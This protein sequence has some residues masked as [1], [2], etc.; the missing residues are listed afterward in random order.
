M[1]TSYDVPF[2]LI[3]TGG[4][5]PVSQELLLQQMRTQSQLAM[6]EADVI[7]FLMDGRAGLT[8]ADREVAAMLRKIKKPVFYVVNK[9]DGDKVE[10]LAAEFYELGIDTFY[11]ISA[12]HNRGVG[13]L[14]DEVTAAFPKNWW[15][16]KRMS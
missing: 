12:A 14:M 11:P 16:K 13:D 3:D 10:A 2:T 6:E 1:S 7:I 15:Q 8:V 4:F 9:V 5:E